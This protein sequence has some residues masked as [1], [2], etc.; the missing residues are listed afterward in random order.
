MGSAPRWCEIANGCKRVSAAQ[1][2]QASLLPVE[3]TPLQDKKGRDA[4]QGFGND[5]RASQSQ[6][7]APRL[8]MAQNLDL[9]C[10]LI[11]DPG[12]LGAGAKTRLHTPK[13]VTYHEQP[14]Y[15]RFM[16]GLNL[17]RTESRI[18]K[19]TPHCVCRPA[20]AAARVAVNYY[21]LKIIMAQHLDSRCVW[22]P[23]LLV[24]AGKLVSN[25]V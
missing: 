2:P 18:K 25:P 16:I 12:T 19:F 5:A 8:K 21:T 11:S 6:I 15:C 22:L 23:A 14:H 17:V 13:S 24:L 4:L 20:A 10:V 1:I 9:G 3:D 7:L